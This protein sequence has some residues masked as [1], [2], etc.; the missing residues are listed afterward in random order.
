[1]RCVDEQCRYGWRN[2]L[3]V[4]VVDDDIYEVR[5]S[6]VIGTVDKFAMMAWRPAASRL[7]GLSGGGAPESRR[8]A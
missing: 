7:F 2:S 3:P 8:P 4:H 5:P 6:I 1:M